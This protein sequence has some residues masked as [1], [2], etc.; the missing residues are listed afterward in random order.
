MPEG[1]SSLC[2]RTSGTIGSQILR[3]RPELLPLARCNR[4][5]VRPC[6]S[7]SYVRPLTSSFSKFGIKIEEF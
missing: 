7:K 1:P 4:E 2:R 3:A 6:S 5:I